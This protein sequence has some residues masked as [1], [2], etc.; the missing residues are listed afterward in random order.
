VASPAR[1]EALRR[2]LHDNYGATLAFD[3]PVVGAVHR[4][5]RK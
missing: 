5:R 2:V 4:L 3:D 1:V